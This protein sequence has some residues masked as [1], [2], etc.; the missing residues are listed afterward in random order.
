M[1]YSLLIG[2]NTHQYTNYKLLILFLYIFY[3]LYNMIHIDEMY[4]QKIL[5][6]MKYTDQ[7]LYYKLN[8]QNY[9]NYNCQ[10]NQQNNYQHILYIVF[11]LNIGYK[12]RLYISW[13][14]LNLLQTLLIKFSHLMI[15]YL[16]LLYYSMKLINRHQN[17]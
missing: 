11:Q 16:K 15:F 4:W 17:Y 12:I 9:I 13:E 1:Q 10:M 8:N 2:D 14:A 3:S 5:H 7:K 6:D